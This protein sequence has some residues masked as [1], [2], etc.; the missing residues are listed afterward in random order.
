MTYHE[1]STFEFEGY[2]L[3]YPEV[4]K[5]RITREQREVAIEL[6]RGDINL[7]RAVDGQM[8][9]VFG[10]IGKELRRMQA[11]R[12][13]LWRNGIPSRV[14]R[15]PHSVTG[16]LILGIWD[17]HEV[18]QSVVHALYG[19]IQ[20]E[21]WIWSEIQVNFKGTELALYKQSQ[22]LGEWLWKVPDSVTL[23]TIDLLLE[24][25]KSP[26]DHLLASYMSK[27]RHTIAARKKRN[28]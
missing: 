5:P 27:R 10:L 23:V 6:A 11:F 16:Y 19:D 12:I 18:F 17:R 7:L 15:I 25:G 24:L 14:Y 1:K 3:S 2:N 22:L 20:A 26:V 28:P 8:I 21:N 4:I 9:S 13:R